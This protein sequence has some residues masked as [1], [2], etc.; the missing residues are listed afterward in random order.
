MLSGLI[1]RGPATWALWQRTVL[2]SLCVPVITNLIGAAWPLLHIKSFEAGFRTSQRV[3]LACNI[4]ARLLQAIGSQPWALAASGGGMK[5]AYLLDAILLIVN[6][7][8]VQEMLLQLT[9]V[10]LVYNTGNAL[11][12]GLD[13]AVHSEALNGRSYSIST[14]TESEFFVLVMLAIIPFHR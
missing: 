4:S 7:D 6:Q 13:Q 9:A 2:L 10:Q 14:M 3:I 8:S 11:G 5:Q 12:P 1:Q